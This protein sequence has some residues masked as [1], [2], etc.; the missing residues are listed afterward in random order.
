MRA[1]TPWSLTIRASAATWTGVGVDARANRPAADLQRATVVGGPYSDMTTLAFN[2]FSGAPATAGT[3]L[4]LFFRARY[5]WLLDTPGTYTL[6]LE[7]TI[8]AP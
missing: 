2:L 3:N 7:L 8:S 1:N 4:T 6:P 5:Q